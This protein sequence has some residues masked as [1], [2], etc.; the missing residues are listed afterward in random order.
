MANR[1]LTS[2]CEVGIAIIGFHL[3]RTRIAS[4]DFANLETAARKISWQKSP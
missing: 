2:A 1:E 3:R 4:P